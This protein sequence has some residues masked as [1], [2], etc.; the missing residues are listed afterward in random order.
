MTK[1]VVLLLI[2]CSAF[3]SP[4]AAFALTSHAQT[5]RV[6]E[7]RRPPERRPPQVTLAERQAVWAENKRE[8]RR[9]VLREG[10]ASANRWLDE[11]VLARR[12]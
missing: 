4:T 10:K 5:L 1:A 3:V 9:R 8:Y 7:L 12:R 6:A 11:R 2:A